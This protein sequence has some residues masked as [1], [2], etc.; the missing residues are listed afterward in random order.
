M[1]SLANGNGSRSGVSLKSS[2]QHATK[3]WQSGK[4]WYRDIVES[5]T[6]SKG[7]SGTDGRASNKELVA[8]SWSVLCR[9]T[10]VPITGGGRQRELLSSSIRRL[11]VGEGK[12]PRKWIDCR[13]HCVGA[14]G[15]PSRKNWSWAI[16]S[17]SHRS[18]RRNAILRTGKSFVRHGRQCA[19]PGSPS[20]LR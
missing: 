8:V 20:I 1:V 16:W 17:R 14:I 18:R 6:K 12:Q 11:L 13:F 4:R 15:L 2:C 9:D 5:N 19:A 10:S 7:G 3:G